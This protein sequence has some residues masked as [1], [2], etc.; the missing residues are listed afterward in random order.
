MSS[1]GDEIA[2]LAVLEGA[3]H[4]LREPAT[5]L[6]S[7]TEELRATP[8]RSG[9]LDATR[10][11]R[12]HRAASRITGLVEAIRPFVRLQRTA[13]VIAR[14]SAEEAFQEVLLR[15]SVLIED[16][17]ASIHH[18]VL[19]DLDTDRPRLVLVLQELLANAIRFRGEHPSVVSVTATRH[20]G[21][22]AFEVADNGIGIEAAYLDRVFAPFERLHSR[23]SYPGHGL[24]LAL[25]RQALGD[26]GGRIWAEPRAGGG[27]HMRFVL[28]SPRTAYPA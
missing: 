13:P 7:F 9:A 17:G 19:P 11:E 27:T 5:H 26:L 12:A 28:P 24:G 23:Q 16:T 20:G 1:T 15:L 10:L 22:V 3:L 18:D 14:V 4:D 6:Q 21:D 25:C 2:L 8:G